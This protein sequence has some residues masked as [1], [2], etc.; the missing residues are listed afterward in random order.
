MSLG[1]NV[2]IAIVFPI[3]PK[4]SIRKSTLSTITRKESQALRSMLL[5]DVNRKIAAQLKIGKDMLSQFG[6]CYYVVKIR[7]IS[8]IEVTILAADAPLSEKRS[9]LQNKQLYSRHSYFGRINFDGKVCRFHRETKIND[10]VTYA[11]GRMLLSFK[12]DTDWLSL[13]YTL[14]QIKQAFQYYQVK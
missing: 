12:L 8:K 10:T 14:K 9:S 13:R 6:R 3:Y 2:P 4:S 1:P 7:N 5:N 11:E